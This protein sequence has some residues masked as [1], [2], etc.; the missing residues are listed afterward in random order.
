MVVSGLQRHAQELVGMRH[1]H[2]ISRFRRRPEAGVPKRMTQIYDLSDPANPVFIRDFGL[3]GQQPGGVGPPP[4][5]PSRQPIS[6][7]RLAIA[8]TSATA[9]LLGGVVADRRSREAAERSEGSDRR[10]NLLLSAGRSARSA[11]ERRRAHRVSAA[12]GWNRHVREVPV[13]SGKSDGQAADAR[14]PRAHQR[15]DRQRMPRGRARWSVS[16]TSRPNRSPSACRTGP[17][18]RRAATSAAR[19]GRFGTHSSN[20]NLRADLLQARHVFLPVQCRRARRRRPRSIQSA[21]DRLLHSGDHRQDRQAL[22]RDRRRHE[23]CKI[24]IQT[25]NVE[26]DDRGYIYIVDR[27]NTGMHILE[28]TGEARRVANLQ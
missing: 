22:R 2:R 18:P 28:L 14:L 23:R 5:E 3:P 1:R 16:P 7:V 11:S 9:P 15:V 21:R 19:G 25:N 26:V 8:C 6:M 13:P 17:C 10:E 20:E 12:R 27:A 4:T 24:A